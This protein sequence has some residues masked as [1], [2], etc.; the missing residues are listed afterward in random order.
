M[1]RSLLGAIVGQ[2]GSALELEDHDGPLEPGREARGR[3]DAETESYEQR[4]GQP[5]ST[6]F[7]LPSHYSPNNPEMG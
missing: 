2:Y 4:E 7:V 3:D 1:L 6:R 5:R